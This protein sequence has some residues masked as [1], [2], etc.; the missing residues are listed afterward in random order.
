MTDS[1]PLKRS[2]RLAP[3]Q[4]PLARAIQSL[5]TLD[6][7]LHLVT[8]FWPIQLAEV[9]QREALLHFVNTWWD[10]TID[11]PP[12]PPMRTIRGKKVPG[13]LIAYLLE[14]DGKPILW[15]D[16][17]HIVAMAY[18]FAIGRAGRAAAQRISYRNGMVPPP[19]PDAES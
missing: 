16:E 15:Y 13:T 7:E 2:F 1:Q 12:V 5:M 14:I 18:A 11:I 8:Y 4:S 17:D 3:G 6:N 10:T 19:D 9:E